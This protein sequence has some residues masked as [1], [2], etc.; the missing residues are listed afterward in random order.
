MRLIRVFAGVSLL[1]TGWAGDRLQGAEPGS[2]VPVSGMGRGRALAMQYCTGCHLLPEPASLTKRAWVHQIQPEMAKWLGLD[3][4]DYESMTDGRLLEAAKLFPSEPIIPEADWF[5]IWDYYR[6]AAPSLP[7]SPPQ[8]AA[9]EPTLRRFRVRVVNPSPGAPMISLVRIQPPIRRVV[10]ADAFA[11]L[12][13]TLSPGGAVLATNRFVSPPVNVAAGQRRSYLTLIGRLFP[14]D[15]EEG[16]VLTLP[17]TLGAATARVILEKL[18]RPTDVV[19]VDLNQDGREDLAVCQF[20]N[21]LG[22]F[23]WFENRGDNHYEERVLQDRPGALGVRSLDMTRD[24]R[25][26][27]I[28]MTAQA[29]EAVQLF[30]NA[31][32]GEFRLR[33]LIEK[34]PTWGFAGFDL[35][36][37]DRDGATDLL[38]VNGDNGDWALPMKAEHGIRLY[39]NNGT[40]EFA[41]TYFY[42]FPGAYKALG[43]D[44]DGDGDLDIAAI[45]Y[46]PDFSAGTVESFVYL[47]NEGGQ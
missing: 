35:V 43:R 27:L 1:L 41:E 26:D 44:F 25:P 5:A 2:S 46:Y 6:A 20:G 23:S 4:V 11:G 17:D 28:L 33:T 18:R 45:A 32:G 39:R 22:R 10:V 19:A 7:P 38:T 47:R 8:R 31:G 21:R 37:F 40:N 15:A 34:P 36:D 3:P 29:R 12:L 42:P 16:A 14:S 30:E 13:W 24:G 9:P